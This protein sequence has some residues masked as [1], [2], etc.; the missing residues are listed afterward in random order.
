MTL[1]SSVAA[2]DRLTGGQGAPPMD[3][4]TTLLD[5]GLICMLF[6]M[7]LGAHHAGHNRYDSILVNSESGLSACNRVGTAPLAKPPEI[8]LLRCSFFAAGRHYLLKR[9]PAAES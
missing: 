4:E 7:I 6:C 3:R 1:R 5:E 9:L 8:V 2:A